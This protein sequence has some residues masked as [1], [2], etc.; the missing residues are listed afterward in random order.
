L[1]TLTKVFIVVTVILSVMCSVVFIQ[2]ALTVSNYKVAWAGERQA[3]DI[4]VANLRDQTDRSDELQANNRD[5]ARQLGKQRMDLLAENKRLRDDAAAG[6]LENLRL[7]SRLAG[8]DSQISA[9]EK[10]YTEQVKMTALLTDQVDA[11]D[12][13]NR[14]QKE[15]LALQQ[16]NLRERERELERATQELTSKGEQLAEAQTTIEKLIKKNADLRA[17]GAVVAA[18]GR[19]T[20]IT[21]PSGA[22]IQGRLTAVD[23][24][25]NVCQ[26]NVGSASGVTK[27]MRFIIFRGEEFVGYVVVSEVEEG[28]SAGD[29]KDLQMSPQQQDSVTTH[30]KMN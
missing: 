30:L 18:G 29:L 2:Q 22:P 27:A 3:K 8:K 13:D 5:L 26:L 16:K 7:T 24:E 23:L 14:A 12:K 9:F 21:P 15:Q 11:R 10:T 28:S 4:A 1:S 25:H 20:V 17:G 19:E 6:A